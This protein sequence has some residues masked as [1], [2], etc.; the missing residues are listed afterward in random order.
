MVIVV[1]VGVS[2]ARLGANIDLVYQ[3]W[4]GSHLIKHKL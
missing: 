2:M 3:N 1:V 4:L